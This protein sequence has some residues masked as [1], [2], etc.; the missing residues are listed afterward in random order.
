MKD[1]PAVETPI[2][3]THVFNVNNIAHQPDIMLR[4]KIRSLINGEPTISQSDKWLILRD[5]AR[6]L[7]NDTL[8]FDEKKVKI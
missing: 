7:K 5:E 8:G 1:E 4:Y 3:H 2:T 6:L